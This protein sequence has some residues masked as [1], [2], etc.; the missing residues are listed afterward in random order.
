MPRSAYAPQ[1][2]MLTAKAPLARPRFNGFPT[3]NRGLGGIL[4]RSGVRGY[5]NQG[6]IAATT[7]MAT[8]S[9]IRGGGTNVVPF[10]DQTDST[11]QVFAGFAAGEWLRV[12]FGA[13]ARVTTCTYRNGVGS[14][15][16]PTEVW[17]QSS[18]DNSA[19]VTETVYGDNATT[20][21][22]TISINTGKT[23]RYW[24]LYQA[25]ATRQNSAGY[26]WHWNRFSMT[27]PNLIEI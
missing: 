23:A 6:T 24:R 21:V 4:R 3:V 25:T 22:Q 8:A 18:Q 2:P 12:D 13:P 15:W 17:V 16:A 5:V 20:S 26:E 19:W 7:A 10:F 1:M 27:A 11:Y 14:A 9:S